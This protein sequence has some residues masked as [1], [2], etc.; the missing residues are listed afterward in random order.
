M[1]FILLPQLSPPYLSHPSLSLS[2]S[3]SLSF[4]LFPPNWFMASS[5]FLSRRLFEAFF[6]TFFPFSLPL[7]PAFRTFALSRRFSSRSEKQPHV[8][9]ALNNVS[10]LFDLH[11]D[12]S[13]TKK[14]NIY[15][16]TYAHSSTHTHTHTHTYVY[17]YI[18]LLFNTC[19]RANSP[20]KNV[21]V[22]IFLFCNLN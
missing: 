14:H 13:K 19:T 6:F 17:I 12:I 21:L 22:F 9:R 4:N 20:R 8:I 18:Y 2:L 3:L 11:S 16:L 15:I 5:E 1:L 7:V 10:V